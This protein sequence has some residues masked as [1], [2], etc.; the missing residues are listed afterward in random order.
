MDVKEL[1]RRYER[2]V[3]LA[4]GEGTALEVLTRT[5]AASEVIHCLLQPV[6]LEFGEL[7]QAQLGEVIGYLDNRRQEAI[8]TI[9]LNGIYQAMSDDDKLHTDIRRHCQRLASDALKPGVNWRDRKA[10]GELALQRGHVLANLDATENL[11]RC[12]LVV[13]AR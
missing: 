2:T 7:T 1:L 3:E 13:G 10:L 11:I 6:E 12:M 4:M 8:R 9:K 5:V